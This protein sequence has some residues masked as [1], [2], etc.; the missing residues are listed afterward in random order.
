MVEFYEGTLETM[1][2]RLQKTIASFDH[3]WSE[4]CIPAT[5]EQIQYLEKIFEQYHYSLPTAYLA[6]LKAMG[7]SDGGLLE[8]EWDG[9]AEPGI[10]G[11]LELFDEEGFYEE[12]DLDL[13]KGYYLFSYHWTGAHM[14][15]RLSEDYNNPVVVKP[16]GEGSVYA[17]G[18]FEKYLFQ[19]AFG[20]YSE[21]FKY[22][23]SVGTS[24]VQMDAVLKKYSY[25][26]SICGGT[27]KE[28]MEFA[29][30]LVKP[31]HVERMWFSDDT[32]YFCLGKQ[33][34]LEID[35]RETMIIVFSCKDAELKKRADIELNKIFD[36][37]TKIVS[38]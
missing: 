16:E 23:V 29:E 18:S 8:R 1:I 33:Y 15:L 31:Y 4:K 35:I 13:E 26:S 3:E 19:K 5:E 22:K 27:R 37:T 25:P 6:Y 20:M 21:K 12:E 28:R 14:Y 10:S 38:S 34:A 11:I 2:E 24:A 30:Y 36:K 7:Q 32:H 9:F 17:S